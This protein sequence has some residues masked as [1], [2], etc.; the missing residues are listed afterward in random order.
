MET[1]AIPDLLDKYNKCWQAY[2]EGSDEDLA[3]A[4]ELAQIKSVPEKTSMF[5]P[6]FRE[7]A[8]VIQMPNTEPE[9]YFAEKK[10]E[11]L[12]NTEDEILKERI[13]YA[14]VWVEQYAP[15][16]ERFKVETHTKTISTPAHIVEW[17]QVFFS[18]LVKA[19]QEEKTPDGL[20][21]TLYTIIKESGFTP[22]EAFVKIYRVLIGKDYG[23]KA[24]WLIWESKEK[25]LTLFK[26]VS[27]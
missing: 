17:D 16:T 2:I 6:R 12:E 27:K 5:L 23:P 19:I 7:V 4:F 15:E 1:M 9:T 21:K 3:R 22:K 26:E 13:I 24:A 20:E 10:G 18:K 14:K 11:K 8:Q 25:A